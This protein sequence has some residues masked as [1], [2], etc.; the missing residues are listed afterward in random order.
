MVCGSVPKAAY[1]PF[2]VLLSVPLDRAA[3]QK[4]GDR[5]GWRTGLFGRGASGRKPFFHGIELWEENR[6]NARGR[7]TGDGRRLNESGSAG[8]FGRDVRSAGGGIRS[9]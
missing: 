4:I 1:A 3:V 8:E 6:L 7:D 9:V 5:K 2:H